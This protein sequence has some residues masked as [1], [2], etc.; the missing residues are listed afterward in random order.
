[1]WETARSQQER[2][3][4]F[5]WGDTR[6]YA[7]RRGGDEGMGDGDSDGV[8]EEGGGAPGLVAGEPGEGALGGRGDGGGGEGGPVKPSP[9]AASGDFEDVWRELVS[10]DG[11][12]VRLVV[13]GG[14]D[15]GGQGGAEEVWVGK[16]SGRVVRDVMRARRGGLCMCVR[17][18]TQCT[19][20]TYTYHAFM[21]YACL[22]AH[23]RTCMHVFMHN[24]PHNANDT[25]PHSALHKTLPGTSRDT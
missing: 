5:P 21:M 20:A 12:H 1:M 9:D 15:G 2:L 25:A 24:A 8:W 7:E 22:L 18:D 17:H 6:K 19:P 11:N 4:A 13:A 10:L 3:G 16:G 14:G 23:A